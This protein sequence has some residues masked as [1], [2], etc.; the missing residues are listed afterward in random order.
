MKPLT[1]PMSGTTVAV[2]STCTLGMAIAAANAG[3]STMAC[4]FSGAG[5]PYTIQ[6][7]TGTTYTFPAPDNFWYGPNALPPIAT[8]ILIQGNG[9]TLQIPFGTPRLRFFYVGADP[10]A[11]ATLNYNTPGAGN[12]TL[13]NLTLTGGVQLGGAGSGGGAGMGGAIFNQGTLSLVNVTLSG[14]SATGGAG[15]NGPT[16][17]GGMGADATSALAGGFGGAVSPQAVPVPLAVA[18][19]EASITLA[20]PRAGACR[21]GWAGPPA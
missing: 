2:N 17:G 21:M 10:T 16:G 19:S 11:T 20:E 8:T 14:N 3:A 15:G 7:Q 9:A 13:Q 5:T 6:L 1:T 12:L 4:P 18:G